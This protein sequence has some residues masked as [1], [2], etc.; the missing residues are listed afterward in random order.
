MDCAFRLRFNRLFGLIGSGD[1]KERHETF[2]NALE[3]FFL[4]VALFAIEYFVYAVFY[5]FRKL[6]GIHPRDVG[7][8]V[9]LLGN[10]VLF[11]AL[12]AYKRLTY[13]SLFHSS[14]SSVLAT[15]G[16]LSIPILFLIPG[17]TLAVAAINSLMVYLFPLSR[18]EE[19]M[20]DQMMSNG[21]ATVISVCILAPVLEEMLFR[22]VILRSFLRLYSRWVAIL[23]SSAIFGLAHLNI[24]QFMVAL[25]IGSIAGWLY[26]RTR[27]LWPCILLHAA[28]NCVVAY[29][30]FSVRGAQSGGAAD[31]TAFHW[32][33]AAIFSFMGGLML[34]RLL[35]S[36]LT[37]ARIASP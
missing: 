17:I 36:K 31:L 25:L 3:A 7:A 24:Y 19:W 14:K 1:M 32:I 37:P 13:T 5:D 10:A 16:L 11:S 30:Y 23:A 12:L 20:F 34:R 35:G 26:E 6:L 27:S 9:T 8:M 33:V 4:I 22:G 28:Y 18:W 15:V 29:E 2:P 21:V